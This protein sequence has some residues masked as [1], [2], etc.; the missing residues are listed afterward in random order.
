MKKILTLVCAS[1]MAFAGATANDVIYHD[2]KKFPLYGSAV[3]NDS[4][5][6]TRLPDS[7]SSKIRKELYD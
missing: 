1:L 2:A 7:L 3:K 6:F 5:D 4:L